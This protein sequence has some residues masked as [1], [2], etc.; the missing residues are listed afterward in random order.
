MK[1]FLEGRKRVQGNDSEQYQKNEH[2]EDD[3]Q[4]FHYIIIKSDCKDN[5][6]FFLAR[7]RGKEFSLPLVFRITSS[8]RN[9]G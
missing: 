5:N 7:K 6:N 2:E 9:F 1:P 3:F 8:W 4:F